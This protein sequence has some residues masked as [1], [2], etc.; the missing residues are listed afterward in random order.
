MVD[1]QVRL[2]R[3]ECV[4]TDQVAEDEE[5]TATTSKQDDP[6]TLPFLSPLTLEPCGV[7]KCDVTHEKMCVCARVR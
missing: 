6:R 2:V 7:R 1:R 4:G 3:T 5:E